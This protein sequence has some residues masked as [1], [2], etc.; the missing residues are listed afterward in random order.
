MANP[1]NRPQTALGTG[2]IQTQAA[3]EQ[4]AQEAAPAAPVERLF[5]VLRDFEVPQGASSYLLRGGKTISSRHYNIDQ[6]R[7]IG[8]PLEQVSGK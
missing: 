8:A 7:S 5:R 3:P 6:L 1:Q 2:T 4:A